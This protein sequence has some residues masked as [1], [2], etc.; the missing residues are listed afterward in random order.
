VTSQ[1][2]TFVSHL[3]SAFLCVI[4]LKVL[5]TQLNA[6][7]RTGSRVTCHSFLNLRLCFSRLSRPARSLLRSESAVLLVDSLY[8]EAI[9]A[10]K[11]LTDLSA[12]SPELIWILGEIYSEARLGPAP[13]P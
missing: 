6:V 4:R 9:E 1:F 10:I 5:A 13:N 7:L 3:P 12:S 8:A 11:S 2:P